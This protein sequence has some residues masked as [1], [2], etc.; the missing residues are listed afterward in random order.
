MVEITVEDREL[1]SELNSLKERYQDLS[2]LMLTLSEDLVFFITENFETEGKRLP[3]DKQWPELSDWTI[4][5]REYKGYWPGKKL[6]Q[7]GI[8]VNSIHP[9]HDSTTASAGTNVPYAEIN[10]FGGI[11]DGG[12]YIPPRPFMELIDQDMED[13]M[14]DVM[15]YLGK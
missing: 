6:H 7:T 2:P 15:K 10:H 14:E 3:P 5:E 8:L 13:M 1:Q 4:N 11:N 12:F 9:E